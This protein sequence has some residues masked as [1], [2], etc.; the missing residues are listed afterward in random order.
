MRV[1]HPILTLSMVA[2]LVAACGGSSGATPKPADQATS[3]PGASAA[4]PTDAGSQATD[5]AKATPGGG[6][7]GGGGGGNA[8][9][10]VVFEISGLVSAKGSLAFAPLSSV[11]SA[12]VINMSFTDASTNTVLGILIIGGTVA[13]SYGT[14]DY[15]V[16]AQYCDAPNLITTASSA[17]GSFDCKEADVVQTSGTTGKGEIK[18]TFEAH[19]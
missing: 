2:I 13:I 12:S 19:Q 7:G 6:G 17:S 10:S 8:S 14:P 18:G 1:S 15:T 11:F 16:A 3:G 5:A 4:A 9:D